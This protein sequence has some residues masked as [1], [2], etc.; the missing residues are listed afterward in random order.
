MEHMGIEIKCQLNSAKHNEQI[1]INENYCPYVIGTKYANNIL[2]IT[3]EDSK[4]MWADF[5]FDRLELLVRREEL[6]IFV[7]RHEVPSDLWNAKKYSNDALQKEK[8]RIQSFG[9]TGFMAMPF[10]V[11]RIGDIVFRRLTRAEIDPYKIEQW[12]DVSW[13]KAQVAMGLAD[14]PPHLHPYP[15]WQQEENERKEGSYIEPTPEELLR[16]RYARKERTDYSGMVGLDGGE[17]SKGNRKNAD[18]RSSGAAKVSKESDNENADG[19]RKTRKNTSKS[20][21]RE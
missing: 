20:K 12:L 16:G 1:S 7:D 3:E 14:S 15:I 10:I 9:G 4:L 11:Y 2:C 18:G 8:K 5:A 17:P 19:V 13:D 6:P 21:N